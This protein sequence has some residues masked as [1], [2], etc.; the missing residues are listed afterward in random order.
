MCINLT[1]ILYVEMGIFL[2]KRVF[3]LHQ[4]PFRC[5]L[6]AKTALLVRF[7]QYRDCFTIAM[8]K[9]ILSVMSYT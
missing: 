4:M 7:Q 2:Q 9:K 6:G 8:K 1:I 5:D 3:I